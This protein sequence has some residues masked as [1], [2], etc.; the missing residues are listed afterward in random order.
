MEKC[1]K[2]TMDGNEAAAYAS[3][4]F[5]EV[6]AIY[7]ITPSSP[8]AEYVDRW[9]ASGKKNIFGNTV[10][11]VEMQ[12][13][14]GAIGA[15]HGAMEAGVLTSTYTASQGLLLMIPAMNRIAGHLKPGVIHVA[16]RSVAYHAYS[17]FAEHSDVMACRQTGYAMLASSSVQQAMD[18]GAVAHLASIKSSVPFLHFFDGFRT[19]HEIQKIGCLDY[20]DLAAMVDWEALGRFRKKALNPEHPL[21]RNSGQSPEFYFQSREACNS[22]YDDV[23]QIVESYMQSINRL[24]GK[25]YH[26]FNY[27]GAEDARTVMVAIGSVSGAAQETVEYLNR[28]G[29]RLGFLEVHLY[30]PFSVRHFLEAIPETTDRVVVLDRTKENGALADPLYADI[31]A[32][33]QESGRNIR[34]IGGRFGI[35]GK[36]TGPREIKAIFDNAMLDR[37]INHFTVGIVDDVTHHSLQ[38]GEPL[39]ISDHGM[40]SCKFWGLG[41][42]GTV[43]ANKNS[44]KIIGENTDLFVQAYFEYDGKKSGGVTKSHLRFGKKEIKSSYYVTHADFVACHQQAYI[45]K[46]DM[47]SDI[48]PGGAFLLNC[49]WKGEQLEKNLPAA[50]KRYLA[51][52]RIHFYII[53][54][55]GIAKGLGMGNHTNTILQAAFFQITGIL[56]MEIAVTQMKSFVQKT[57]GRKGESVVA[58]NCAAIDRGA[59]SVQEIRIPEEWKAA[60]GWEEEDKQ[61]SLPPYVTAIM[62]P[63]LAQRGDSLPVSV[64][65]D[66]ADG[67]MPS[68]TSKY[69]RRGIALEVPCWQPDQCIACN[70]CA[71]VCPHAA[72]RPFLLTQKEQEQA[73]KGMASIKAKGKAL[74]DYYFRIQVDP[75]DC[76]GCGSCVSV[77]P[78]PEKALSMKPLDTQMHEMEN[79]EYAIA[80]TERNPLGTGSVRGSQFARPLL[81][82]PGACPGCGETPYMKLVTQLF[83]ER[84]Y[85]ATATGCSLVW[86]TDYP[87]APYTV[88][89]RGRGPAMSNSLFEN[90]GEFGFGMAIGVKALREK[91]RA[92]AERLM[93]ASGDRTVRESIARW[94]ESYGC[95]ERNQADSDTLREALLALPEEERRGEDVCFLLDNAEHL[96]KKSV[97]IFGGDG[98]AYD[99]GYGGLDHVLAMGEDV[100]ILVVDTEVYSNTGGQASKA[101]AK[102]AVAQFA[103]AGCQRRKKDLGLMAMAYEEVY[104]AQ[105][106][107]GADKAQLLK[108]LL[109]AESYPGPSLVI[110]YAPCQGHGLKCGMAN[111]QEE[112]KKA[113]ASGYWKLYRYDPRRRKEGKN[114]FILDSPEPSMELSD[115]MHGEVRF[116]SLEKVFPERAKGLLTEASK[117]AEEQYRK[118]RRIADGE[119][120]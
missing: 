60:D 67:S 117:E 12:S 101:T 70:Q 86:A 3:Y 36:D 51:V 75:V 27:Y 102:G 56:P 47:Y 25:N 99:I 29:Y 53:D 4:A 52:N 112:M 103:A 83:G 79:W 118:Y 110:A 9:A 48:K 106:A 35:G 11:L 41:S 19:S 90:N 7:P 46:Y 34:V 63:I 82:F 54:A 1:K 119:I 98:W 6:A 50:L 116:A 49:S 23:P 44:I 73:P 71:Y 108:A 21:V 88:N 30:R 57:Y 113:V 77:C 120:T 89:A 5:T 96:A 43:G 58:L 18:L 45:H 10:R 26:L 37:P 109:E 42:D 74:Q 17:I 107:M 87:A 8:M 115:F 69:E 65:M 85:I 81:E 95:G 13:E 24:T 80:L 40:M 78:A 28:H 94:L 33:F 66:Y 16:S 72:I 15:V 59:A 22:Y 2:R 104:V 68:G 14:A 39:D 76:V 55:T 31:C 62:K 20:G 111:V 97:W 105:V 61:L 84:M 32:A 91:I 92:A 100:N 38:L 114:P 93:K 64:F